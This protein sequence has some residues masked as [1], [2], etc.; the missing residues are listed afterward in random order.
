MRRKE[1]L[2]NSIEPHQVT[3]QWLWEKKFPRM[4]WELAKEVAAPACNKLTML[5]IENFE[6][7]SS[8]E[9]YCN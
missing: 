4:G 2:K 3:Y 8:Y 9:W 7:G 1:N 5:D 6:E